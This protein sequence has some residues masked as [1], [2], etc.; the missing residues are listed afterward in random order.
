MVQRIL[1]RSQGSARYTASLTAQAGGLVLQAD[2]DLVGMA[3][4]GIAP[5]RKAAGEVLPLRVEKTS[6]TVRTT[7]A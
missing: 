5:L 7:C 1:D 2:S 3:I 4:D 6:R